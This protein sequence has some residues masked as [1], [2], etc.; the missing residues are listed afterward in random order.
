MPQPSVDQLEVPATQGSR[1]PRPSK[2][3]ALENAAW[4]RLK[5]KTY[6]KN[7]PNSATTDPRT[8]KVNVPPPKKKRRSNTDTFST[9]VDSELPVEDPNDEETNEAPRRQ[10]HTTTTN[11]S[12]K[13]P[14]HLE[15]RQ[16]ALTHSSEDEF[17][18]EDKSQDDDNEEDENNEEDETT[19][20]FLDS[21]MKRYDRHSTTSY[22]D[23]ASDHG[24]VD[25]NDFNVDDF[26]VDNGVAN[27]GG[28]N[29]ND[30]HDDINN[31]IDGIDVNYHS[32]D[33]DD[34]DNLGGPQAHARGPLSKRAA[35]RRA[36]L[37][38]LS[39][40]NYGAPPASTTALSAERNA[41]WP[42]APICPPGPRQRN[43]LI[44]LQ[45]EDFKAIL[46]EGIQSLH[47]YCAFRQGYIP[48]D[49][50]TD[51]F[52]ELLI[53][54]ATKLNKPHYG[55][56]LQKDVVLQK[57]VCDLLSGRVSHYRTTIKQ[58]AVNL[59]SHGY[60]L[61]NDESMRVRQVKDLI[62]NDKF[63]FEP[64]DDGGINST[65]P[66]QHP[67]I[68]D[69]LRG[70][71]FKRKRGSTFAQKNRRCFP[72]GLSSVTLELPPAM[73]AIVAVAVHASLEEKAYG[74]EFNADAYEDSYYIH[75]ATLKEIE[76][77]NKPAYRRLMS[78]LYKL[79]T[80]DP[81]TRVRDSSSN[82]MV[83]LDLNGMAV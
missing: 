55:A 50:Q 48:M 81:K 66:F 10:A 27:Y 15:R 32:A 13:V 7:I 64:K 59:V 74:I 62:N 56:R 65:R 16:K 53:K 31:N 23:E 17:G 1:L 76:D 78:D 36:E 60:K 11:N 73:V 2:T 80:D 24:D 14:P 71:F 44:S 22:E 33:D 67:V 37:V 19:R 52:I 70:A 35:D 4:R 26:D 43:L 34:D 75:I 39:D 20:T 77:N 83:L 41:R 72:L 28:V 5:P 51:H 29:I 49:A 8:T 9:A 58:V 69:T 18:P 6:P 21:T 42:H 57:E 79:V 61:E 82:A 3:R 30:A 38:V 12:C 68:V 46:K 47:R 63:I 54:T 25:V 45:P 40:N